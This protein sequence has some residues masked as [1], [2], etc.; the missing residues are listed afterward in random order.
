M[1]KKTT[2]TIHKLPTVQDGFQW[3]GSLSAVQ[4]DGIG[5]PARS[6]I[7]H[8]YQYEL[9]PERHWSGIGPNVCIDFTRRYNEDIETYKQMGINSVRYGFMWAR[10]FPDG[11]TLNKEAVK[12]YHE[13]IDA[14]NAAN[15]NVIM[16]LHHFDQPM[17]IKELGGWQNPIVQKRFGEFAKFCFKE[18]GSKVERFS[19]F[20]E[21]AV[22]KGVFSSPDWWIDGKPSLERTY[23]ECFGLMLSNAHAFYEFDKL[24]KAGKLLPKATLGVVI[25]Y[26]KSYPVDPKNATKADWEAVRF[27]DAFQNKFWTD[28][29]IIGKVNDDVRLAFE[30]QGF[31][32]PITKE[33][34]K[35]MSKVRLDFM[36][37]NYYLPWRA[38]ARPES[39]K[40]KNPTDPEFNMY[41]SGAMKGARM[42]HFRGWEIFAE[43]L[44]GTLMDL[45]EMYGVELYVGENGMG[46]DNE[47]RFRGKDGMIDD[48]YRISYVKEHLIALND[49]IKGGA[50]IFGYHVWSITDLWSSF[51][52]FK[53]RYGFVEIN[54]NNNLERKL[55]KSAL[56]Y[57]EFVR[58]GLIEDGFKKCDVITKKAMDESL[59]IQAKLS[60]GAKTNY[61]MIMEQGKAKKPETKKG[62]K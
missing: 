2:K 19:T 14:F 58:T 49:A 23:A 32:L 25:N 27:Q 33:Q 29:M 37:E 42:N 46:V 26:N 1:T 20:N 4:V 8:D 18:Y 7:W 17:W 35:F 6:K 47:E 50:R 61:D 36:G 45:H 13:I 16:Q 31:K 21:P 43:G 24:R 12:L 41:K 62:K 38:E 56:W 34:E 11:V 59:K 52:S 48:E 40:Q 5:K 39:E 60:T 51:N 54:M 15:I 55:K 3:G 53:N 10:L 22:M 57:K 9:Y 28:G 44:T 30:Q